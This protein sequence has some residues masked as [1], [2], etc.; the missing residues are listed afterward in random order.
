MRVATGRP[1]GVDF[2][3]GGTARAHESVTGDVVT[4]VL[5]LVWTVGAGGNVSDLEIT[6][7][8]IGRDGRKC[9]LCGVWS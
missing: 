9:R 7:L 1:R 5:C 3:V 6:L 2:L 8:T 4:L